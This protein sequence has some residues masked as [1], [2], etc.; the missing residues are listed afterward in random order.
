M[1]T[2]VAV[3]ETLA[4]LVVIALARMSAQAEAEACCC[5]YSC[6]V[7]DPDAIVVSEEA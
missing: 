3:V 2:F 4:C 1:E 5:P 7:H 6:V